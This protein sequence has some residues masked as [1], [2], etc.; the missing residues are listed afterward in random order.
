MKV[1]FPVGKD[2]GLESCLYGHFAS[3]PL[4]IEID[5][6][7]DEVASLTNCDQLAPEA[8]CNP[9][10][11]LVNRKLDAVIVDGIGDGYLRMLNSFGM[12]VLQAQFASVK[13]NIELL[14]Q[15]ALPE[16]EML[17][18]AEAGRCSDGEGEHT[19]DHSHDE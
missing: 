6:E 16:V 5:T 7:T 8:G 2:A 17:D 12:R 11:A 18:S 4:F 3:A 19:C 1:C 13:D 10:N 14:K 15:D 9:F